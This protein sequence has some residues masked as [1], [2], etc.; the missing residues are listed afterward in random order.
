[1]RAEEIAEPRMAAQHDQAKLEHL[2]S[3]IDEGIQALDR[4]DFV[5][6]DD[7]ELEAFLDNLLILRNELTEKTASQTPSL[8]N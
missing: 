7:A 8:G 1:M 2:R 4:G 5:E 6:V 3:M